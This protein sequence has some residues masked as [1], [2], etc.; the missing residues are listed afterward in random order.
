VPESTLK[1]ALDIEGLRY[2][3]SMSRAVEPGNS[4][5]GIQDHEAIS[6]D[7]PDHQQCA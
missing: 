2:I 3:P 5:R 1:S 6:H 7:L 4:P